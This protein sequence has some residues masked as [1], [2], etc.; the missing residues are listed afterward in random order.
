MG[1][2]IVFI[3][4]ALVIV[5][6]GFF[7]QVNLPTISVAAERLFS[8][9]SFSVTNALLTSWI[10]TILIVLVVFLATRNM[11]SRPSGL[12]NFIEFVVEGVYNLTESVSGREWA[13]RFFAIPAT[14][15]IFVLVANWFGLFIGV[16]LAGLGLC[17]GGEHGEEGEHAALLLAS[18]EGAPVA[19]EGEE[20]VGTCQPGQHIVPFFRAPSADL[21]FTLALA[22]ITQLASWYFGI[23]A[24]GFG[25]FMGKFLQFGEL[26]KGGGIGGFALGLI[27]F[28]VGLIE[29]MSEFIKIIAFTFRLFGNI[30]AGEVMLFVIIFLAPLLVITPL[31]GFEIFV[32]FIQA[33]VFFILSVA[34]Y[35]VS[36][37][38]HGGEHH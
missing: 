34:F 16:P 27:N 30:F 7:L 3:V 26:T 14:I 21:N 18:T 28:A 9:G 13:P 17:E 8:I 32:G 38:P 36:I 31:I 35:T 22:V 23:A 37:K 25:G 12:Q 6:A 1:R 2:T 10:A 5:I 20:A 33:F 19:A 11:Q 29:L 24:L 4:I 15:F